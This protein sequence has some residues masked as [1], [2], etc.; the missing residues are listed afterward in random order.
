MEVLRGVSQG[1]RGDDSNNKMDFKRICM[2]WGVW[3][4][5]LSRGK[6]KNKKSAN[7]IITNT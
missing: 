1:W 6:N 7:E 4:L 3:R 5:S 2:Q